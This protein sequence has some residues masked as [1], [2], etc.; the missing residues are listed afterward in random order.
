MTIPKY[1]DKPKG[2]AALP[3]LELLRQLDPKV[4]CERQFDWLY[5]PKESELLPEELVVRNELIDHCRRTRMNHPKKSLCNPDSLLSDQA[6]KGR[7]RM[8]E[9]DFFLPQYGLGVEFDERQHFTVERKIALAA[10]PATDFPFDRT[11]WAELCS[12]SIL[13]YDPPCRD[14]QR[15]FRDS[16]RDFRCK[17]N[18]L[19][20]LR[21][22]Y[23]ELPE[24]IKARMENAT[25]LA[26]EE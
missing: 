5:L 11:K 10:Y 23:R 15:A 3:L 1:A 22:F 14:W 17:A 24:A 8:L 25:S 19:T 12:D 7:A 4:Q 9:L 16:V 6:S 18:N 2:K 21:I 13:D 20:L 26:R